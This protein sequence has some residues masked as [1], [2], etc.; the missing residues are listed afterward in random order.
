MKIIL[1][2]V[3]GIILVAALSFG[4]WLMSRKVNYHF[5]YK[6]MVEQT[7]REMVKPEALK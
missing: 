6:S 7:V 5:Q 1:L 3:V 2:Y 4:G